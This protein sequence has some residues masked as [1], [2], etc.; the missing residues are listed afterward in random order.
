MAKLKCQGHCCNR[1]AVMDIVFG[2][3][4]EQ[5]RV[6]WCAHCAAPE[7]WNDYP[8]HHAEAYNQDWE[9]PAWEKDKKPQCT[10]C[11]ELGRNVW[12]GKGYCTECFN[13][14]SGMNKL[15]KSPLGVMDDLIK[16]SYEKLGDPATQAL[17]SRQP[18]YEGGI[19][20]ITFGQDNLKPEEMNG[21]YKMNVIKYVARCDRKNGLEDL[22]KAQDYLNLLIVS[23][24]DK[25]EESSVI[26]KVEKE[27]AKREK[28]QTVED[29]HNIDVYV[30]DLKSKGDTLIPREIGETVA[31]MVVDWANEHYNNVSCYECLDGYGVVVCNKKGKRGKAMLV[32]KW[33]T[34]E[35]S[36]FFMEKCERLDRKSPLIKE[37]WE[38]E[39]TAKVVTH[40]VNLF[41]ESERV[42]LEACIPKEIKHA[43]LAKLRALGYN[44][45][46]GIYGDGEMDISRA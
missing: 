16:K 29:M 9:A 2:E 44:L 22:Q 6:P 24:E 11:G 17:Y 5:A 40:Y 37:N 30:N 4:A 39:E 7:Y 23:Y 20:P 33:E 41:K 3:L 10:K 26:R 12:R 27:V 28:Q 34:E 8:Y 19:D 13:E 25:F 46:T 38:T 1:E 45:D 42:T 18:H 36:E 14:V 31:D 35:S 21:F 32:D 15:E 43:I